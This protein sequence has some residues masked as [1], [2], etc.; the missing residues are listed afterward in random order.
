M[1]LSLWYCSVDSKSAASSLSAGRKLSQ[2]QCHYFNPTLMA[3]AT[4][5]YIWFIIWSIIL[6]WM[7]D[8]QMKYIIAIAE[9]SSWSKAS[10]RETAVL[11]KVTWHLHNSDRVDGSIER[12]WYW[13]SVTLSSSRETA[14]M[15]RECNMT[16]AQWS[17]M[18]KCYMQTMLGLWR[19]HTFCSTQSVQ[20]TPY[21]PDKKTKY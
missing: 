15:L 12:R 1:F 16:L 2:T 3:L 7:S 21:L 8:K 18:Q 4:S 5:H 11:W 13:D 10:A 17:W 19:G 6:I 20:Q 9:R 14:V